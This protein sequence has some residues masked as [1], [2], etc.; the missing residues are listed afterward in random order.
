MAIEDAD[1][2]A[3]LIA[4][5]RQRGAQSS[6]CPSELARQLAPRDWRALMPRVRAV[7]SRLAAQG[8]IDITQGGVAVPA[9]GP[10]KGPI[11]LRLPARHPGGGDAAAPDQPS[12]A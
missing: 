11:R 7:A 12:P 9:Q 5:V 8:R 3:A 10:W 2:A 4:L 1:I 6:A